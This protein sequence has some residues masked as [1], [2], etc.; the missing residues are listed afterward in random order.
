MN[1]EVVTLAEKTIAGVKAVTSNTDPKMTEIIGGLWHSFGSETYDKIQGKV[2]KKSIGLYCDYGRPSK[3]DYTVVAGA[4]VNTLDGNNDFAI[5]TIPVGK[6]AK[7]TVVGDFATATGQCW[8][9]IWSLPLERKFTGDFEEYQEDCDGKFG[10][11]IIYIAI[12]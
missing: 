5:K 12:K 8:Q 6:Y 9:E 7:F 2:N 10:T 1:Y 4:E 3:D 11:I